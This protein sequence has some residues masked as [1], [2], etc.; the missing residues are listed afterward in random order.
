MEDSLT[1]ILYF[2]IAL[3]V[4][5]LWSKDYRLQ[6]EKGPQ[7]RALPGAT[8]VALPII[9]FGILGAF[10]LLAL[11]TGGEIIFGYHTEQT[12]ISAFF[13][14]SML[15]AAIVEEVIFRGYLV[16]R[17][18]GKA[19][20]I[21]SIIGFSLF[22]TL[23]HPYLWE[24]PKEEGSGLFGITGITLNLSGKAL[25]SSTFIFLNSLWFYYLRFA[26]AN[27]HRSLLPCFAAHFVGNL[28]VFL[29]KAV[30][31]YVEF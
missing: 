30:Q 8:S 31:G 13:L 27:P 20:L 15:A 10:A 17:E 22:F 5:W 1:N 19:A 7:P 21:L 16:V 29:V 28:G 26:P 23:I 18:K 4:L 11:E 3:Y 25:F 9:L 12:T 14:F 24:V 6:K 2:G